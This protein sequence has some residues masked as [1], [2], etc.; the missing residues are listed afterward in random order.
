MDFG[1]GYLLRLGAG[2]L[3]VWCSALPRLGREAPG[4]N[5]GVSLGVIGLRSLTVVV[6]AGWLTLPALAEEAAVVQTALVAGNSTPNAPS[7]PAAPPTPL[8]IPENYKLLS[9]PEQSIDVVYPGNLME[10]TYSADKDLDV[11]ANQ[12]PKSS[13]ANVMSA[14]LK[15]GGY[16]SAYKHDVGVAVFSCEVIF[17]GTG[18]QLDE[19]LKQF[20]DSHAGAAATALRI[21]SGLAVALPVPVIS[22]GQ[23][24]EYAPAEIAED[25]LKDFGRPF[26]NNEYSFLTRVCS[27]R[28]WRSPTCGYLTV[29][30]H[31]PV[32]TKPEEAVLKAM[33]A[34]FRRGLLLSARFTSPLKQ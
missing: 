19:R 8:V 2:Q 10:V 22:F 28:P 27:T 20:R 9:L 3:A 34:A 14:A 29:I 23:T 13:C 16:R 30:L 32:E 4:E 26:D 5:G 1:L 21:V 17:A 11:R 7:V 25:Y 31:Q 33:R 6:L 24:F 15:D 12:M 18:K